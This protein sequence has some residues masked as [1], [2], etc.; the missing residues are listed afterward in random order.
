MD[1]S[2][3]ELWDTETANLIET[4]TTE[5]EALMD[6]AKATRLNGTDGLTALL[7]GRVDADGRSHVIARGEALAERALAPSLP[8]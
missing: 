4:Y 1:G 8:R 7:L 5:E 2:R 3:F 6:I